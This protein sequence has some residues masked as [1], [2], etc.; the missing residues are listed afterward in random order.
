M[1]PPMKKP[2]RLVMARNRFRSWRARASFQVALQTTWVV[3]LALILKSALVLFVSVAT[4]HIAQAEAAARPSAENQTPQDVTVKES[5]RTI[6][7]I[8]DS[9]TAGYGVK[10][11]EAFPARVEQMLLAKGHKVKVINGGISGSVTAEADRRLKWYLRAKPDILVLALGANDALKGTPP[12]VIKANLAKVVDLAQANG[13]RVVLA[14]IQ[15]FSNY[16]ADY[17]REFEAVYKE[18]ASEK[19]LVLIPFLLEGV[20]LKKDLNQPDGKHPNAKGHE[21]I[22]EHVTRTLEPLL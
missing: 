19:K 15:I 11:N 12:R 16:G 5:T 20:A 18:L 6:L 21:I 8:G 1:K 2:I 4:P 22:A 13:I 17:R 9:L 10:K 3:T 14:G 7:F